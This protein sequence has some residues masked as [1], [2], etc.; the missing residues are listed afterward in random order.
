MPFI[1]LKVLIE[2]FKIN[3]AIGTES[4]SQIF[5]AFVAFKIV[6]LLR[7]VLKTLEQPFDGGLLALHFK[8]IVF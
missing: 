4:S 1:V 2:L 3:V 7:E 5:I 8:C 6:C